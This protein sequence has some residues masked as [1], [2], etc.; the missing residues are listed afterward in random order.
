MPT[1]LQPLAM[2]VHADQ[3]KSASLIVPSLRCRS[4]L[5]SCSRHE[6]SDPV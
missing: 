3:L 5:S 6:V 2:L 4:T 1:P